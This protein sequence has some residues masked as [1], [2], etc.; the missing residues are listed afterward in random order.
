MQKYVWKKST[1]S[2]YVRTEKFWAQKKS[3]LSETS[4]MGWEA[5]N[6]CEAS[7]ISKPNMYLDYKYLL[8]GSDN[9]D[10]V[11]IWSIIRPY[12]PKNKKIFS[13]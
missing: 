9:P 3:I 13:V 8:F 6:N 11:C 10:E 5:T 2:K 4:R 7:G 12:L 1:F